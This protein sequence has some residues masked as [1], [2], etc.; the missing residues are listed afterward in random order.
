MGCGASTPVAEVKH[1]QITELESGVSRSAAARER[2]EIGEASTLK[3]RA[4]DGSFMSSVLKARIECEDDAEVM[5]DCCLRLQAHNRRV[6]E[7]I[8]VYDSESIHE[9]MNGGLKFVLLVLPSFLHHESA[10][11]AGSHSAQPHTARATDG[12]RTATGAR[13]CPCGRRKREMHSARRLESTIGQGPH[14]RHEWQT[15]MKRVNPT[16]SRLMEISPQTE[17]PSQ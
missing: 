4:G 11:T 12:S 1:E 2:L 7:Y 15:R 6:K 13:P 14:G 5:K 8:A 10:R 17:S 16:L 9:A 3:A